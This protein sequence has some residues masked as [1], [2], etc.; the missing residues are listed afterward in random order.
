MTDLDLD[1]D[2]TDPDTFGSGFPHAYFAARRATEP[3]FF[4]RGRSVPLD[5]WA[6]TK[7]H[8]L[9]AVSRD[10]TTFSSA[11]GGVLLE[12]SIGG[13]ELMLVNQDPPRHTRLR[14][15]V[16]RMFTP[17]YIREL[18]P[19]MRTSATQLVDR[20][21]EL[22][23]FDFVTEVAAELPLIVIA[24]L[25]GIP[26]DDRGKVFDW[27]NRMIGRADPEYGISDSA[28]IETA[29]SAAAELFAYAAQLAE[30]RAADPRDDIVSKLL[31][32]EVDGEQLSHDEFI[33]FFLLLAVAGNETTR[34]LISGGAVAL[35]EFPDQYQLLVSQRDQLLGSAVEE[36][37]RFVSPV[38]SFRRT[39]TR[40]CEIRGVSIREGDAVVMFYGSANRDEDV[41]PDPD[42]FDVTRNPNDHVAFGGRGPHH[43]LGANLA[44]EEIRILYDELLSRA[45]LEIVGAPQRLRSNLI[46]GIKHLPVRLTPRV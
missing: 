33:F 41:Y 32:S 14:N 16:A 45:D 7:Y 29:T 37:L 15:L 24:D 43:C 34:N 1:L 8:D 23:E 31:T 30:A 22:G 9:I 28:A 20:A 4:H 17:R 36:M 44:R 38:I 18:V 6:V 5:F 13:A 10:A 40:D 26:Q 42:R 46:S 12:D 21:I 19:M 2:L 3:V 25:L 27:S 39:A 35:G 11:R